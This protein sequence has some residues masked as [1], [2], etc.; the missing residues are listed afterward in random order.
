MRTFILKTIVITIAVYILFQ[1]TLGQVINDISSK[2]KLVSKT[3]RYPLRR[4][5]IGVLTHTTASD[6]LWEVMKLWPCL[7]IE[8]TH[9]GFPSGAAG[10]L[11]SE[12]DPGCII[13]TLNTYQTTF[14]SDILWYTSRYW[15]SF[16]RKD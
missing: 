12:D 5:I 15:V 10:P 16:G 11:G 2:L 13:F 3:K 1:F 8:Y 9:L 7:K 4:Y 6:W 14:I